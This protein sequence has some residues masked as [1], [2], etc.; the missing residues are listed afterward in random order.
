MSSDTSRRL[1]IV[2][3]G[4]TGC[5]A[6]HVFSRKGWKVTVFDDQRPEAGSKASAGVIHS[7]W[8]SDFDTQE[9][10]DG[11]A[12]LDKLFGLQT[13]NVGKHTVSWVGPE[14]FLQLP[15]P[16][17]TFHQSTVKA[18]GNGWVIDGSGTTHVGLVYVATGSW[19]NELLQA[20]FLIPAIQGRMG[21]AFLWQGRWIGMTLQEWAP[22]K[23]LMVFQQEPG[24]VWSG[25]GTAILPKNYT[26]AREAQSLARIRAV[27]DPSL[28]V[29]TPAGPTAIRGIRPYMKGRTGLF[30]QTHDRTWCSTAGN[31]SGTIWAAISARRLWEAV[32]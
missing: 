16:G 32:K 8:V 23:Q 26:D 13:L 1:L 30:Q 14:R 15:A 28:T 24:L 2:G 31:K 25:D 9:V 29:F 3:A 11:L 22:Y 12:L 10:F 5:V 19:A 6:A 20:G 27:V 21:T 17:V 18:V 4:V 7:G